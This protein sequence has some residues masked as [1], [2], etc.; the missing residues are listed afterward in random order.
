MKPTAQLT[1]HSSTP[2]ATWRLILDRESDGATNMAVDQ[3][4]V[5]SMRQGE[6]PPTLRFYA[7]SPP[8]LSLGR[9]QSLADADLAACRAAGVDVVRRVTGGRAILHTDELTYSIA[10]LQ[11]D[12][13]AAG[14][15]VESY[16]R[17]STGLLA[18]LHRLGVQ[19]A[20]A[21]GQRNAVADLTAVC[22]ET[23]SNYEIT[24]GGRK[25]VGSAQWRTRG[26]VLQ[27]GTLPLC[28]DITRIV[29]CLALSDVDREAQRSDLRHRATT[30]QEALGRVVPFA[31][32][33][34]A[35]AEG[36]AQALDLTL[37]PGELIPQERAL[38]GELRHSRYANP[39]WIAHC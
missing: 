16:R 34:Q 14:G 21:T 28:G 3:A 22:F 39:D 27:H 6:S 17:L 8:C 36:F 1:T 29:A 26:G 5:T 9:G 20:Q 13:R 31:Q 10:L 37:I 35:L 4:I 23:P 24:A 12:P 32:V 25:L 2:S 30:L 18:G 33:A 11:T 15:I 38:A 19:A 7:W